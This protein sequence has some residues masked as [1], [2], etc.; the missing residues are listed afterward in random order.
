MNY[1]RKYFLINAIPFILL[2]LILAGAG[3]GCLL[4]GNL[5]LMLLS[6]IPFGMSIAIGCF[7]VVGNAINQSE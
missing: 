7:L 3:G 2:A 1:S 6:V 4:S 5:A